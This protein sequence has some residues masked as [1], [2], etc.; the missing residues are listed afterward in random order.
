MAYA[1]LGDLIDAFGEDEILQL[2]DR[3]QLGIVDSDVV[4]A[5]ANRSQSLIDGYLAG[6]YALPLVAPYPPIII[7]LDADLQRYY[8]HDNAASERVIAGYQDA[9]RLLEHIQSGRV[10]LPL[11]TA[12]S[13][14]Y[15]GDVVISGAVRVFSRA[16]LAGF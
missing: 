2:A 14:D 4:A 7:G 11:P 15:S 13:V 9:K 12:A 10:T 8:L 3:Q 1:T 5:V 16:T 6:R